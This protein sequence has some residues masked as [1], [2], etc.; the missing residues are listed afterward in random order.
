MWY[1]AVRNK[2]PMLF[3]LYESF[4]IMNSFMGAGLFLWIGLSL[5]P[6]FLLFNSEFDLMATFKLLYER[7][8]FLRSNILIKFGRHFVHV[9]EYFA[10]FYC[11]IFLKF[12][13]YRP[14]YSMSY[15]FA[16]QPEPM[17]RKQEANV[18]LIRI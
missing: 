4:F 18:H 1:A 17:Q 3:N 12:L 5:A 8:F 11:Y 7:I 14:H 16:P 13:V 6:F 2:S 10:W 9:A 15:L